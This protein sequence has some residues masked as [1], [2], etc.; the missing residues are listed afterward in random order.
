MKLAIVLLLLVSGFS[1]A[2]S[3]LSQSLLTCSAIKGTEARLACYDDLANQAAPPETRSTD[4]W[5]VSV[6]TNPV[7]DSQTV[8]MST[9]A[10][11]RSSRSTFGDTFELNLRCRSGELDAWIEWQDFLGSDTILVT[12]RIGTA[13]AMTDTWYVSTDGSASFFSVNQNPT[14]QFIEAIAASDSGQLVAQTTPYSEDTS[15]AIFNTRGLSGLLD[16][17]YEPCP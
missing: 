17:L 4:N 1:Y 15:T 2:Q 11:E 7:D 9:D 16:Q 12:Y 14:R 13:A 8:F 10:V 5:Y 6:D 3:N